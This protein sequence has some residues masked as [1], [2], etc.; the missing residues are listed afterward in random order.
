MKEQE[1]EVIWRII[2]DY[3]I[4]E[5]SNLGEVRKVDNGRIIGEYYPKIELLEEETR[6]RKLVSIHR[7][8]AKAFIPNPRNKPFVNHIDGDKTNYS[9]DNLEWVTHRENVDH[10]IES[11]YYDQDRGLPVIGKNL[12]TGEIREWKNGRTA[13][14]EVGF[15][16]TAVSSACLGKTGRVGLWKFVF[17]KDYNNN[18]F[19]DLTYI[20]IHNTK[21][22][23]QL[24]SN[25]GEVIAEFTSAR[26]A[27][28]ITGALFSK[29]CLVCQGKRSKTGGFGW[30]YKDDT[31]DLKFPDKEDRTQVAI[32]NLVP[33]VNKR[34]VVQIDTKTNE[35][36]AEYESAKIAEEKTG[37]FRSAI[38]VSCKNENRTAGG[39]KWKYKEEVKEIINQ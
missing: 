14:E 23:L 8:I 12:E 21:A 3:P 20:P 5:I 7:L 9:L 27:E 39:F 30:R 2:E 31:L 18:S 37:A 34:A 26:E 10:A 36:I 28:R 11:G 22:V 25:T 13:S 33:G 32:M 6:T 1:N 24:D 19:S 29:I 35:I 16:I 15:S 38:C 4:Y 17:K